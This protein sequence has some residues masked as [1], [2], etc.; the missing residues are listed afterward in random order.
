MKSYR[1]I[2]GEYE[3]KIEIKRSIF[4]ATVKGELNADEAEDFVK[5][6]RKSIPT[7]RIT[8]MRTS[9]TNSE[10]SRDSATTASRRVRRDN[11]YSTYFA[12]RI[13]SKRQSS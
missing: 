7:P 11:P 9:A 2:D 13:S 4:I 12:S 1:Y 10:T 5:S 3:V 8:A 6:V